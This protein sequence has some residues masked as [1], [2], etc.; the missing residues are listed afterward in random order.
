MHQTASEYGIPSKLFTRRWSA[1]AGWISLVFGIL[2]GPSVTATETMP[3][4]LAQTSADLHDHN[5]Y[6]E[7]TSPWLDEVRAQRQAW[8]ARRNQA[9]EAYD[10]RRRLHNPRGAAQQDAWKEEVR[11]QRAERLELIAR[12]RELFLDLGP[13]GF[14]LLWPGTIP[15]PFSSN[16]QDG[17]SVPKESMFAPPGWDNLWYFRGY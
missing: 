3:M 15:I 10:A 4:Q 13:K 14:Q 8:E 17:F 11:R 9:R 2:V 7:V 16:G 6:P 12:D 5:P 1:V